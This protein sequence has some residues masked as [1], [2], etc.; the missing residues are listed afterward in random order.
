LQDAERLALSRAPDIA[1]AFFRAEAAKQVVKQARSAYFPQIT[2]NIAAVATFDDIAGSLGRSPVTGEDT[3]IGASGGLNNPT[4]LSREANGINATQ[5]LTDFGR[6][7]Y[8][9]T[10]AQYDA[11]SEAQRMQ[12]T[13]AQ[14][15][16]WVDQAYFHVLE[17]QALLHVAHE[18]VENRQ[19]IL[20]RATAFAKVELRSNLD[21]SF[22]NVGVQQARLF[23]LETETRLGSAAADLT[24][25]LGFREPRRFV[26][27][28]TTV[29]APPSQELPFLVSEALES[30]PD[31]QAL[32]LQRDS[33][34]KRASAEKVAGLPR[35]SFATS[36][37]RTAMGEERIRQTYG[38]AGVL[39]EVPIFTGGR[40]TAR[41][42]EA[43]LRAQ[44]AQQTVESAEM[45]VTRDVNITWLSMAGARKK[46]DVTET[47]LTSATD[48][49]ELA[50]S[51]YE[52][53]VASLLELS[54]ADL[55][56]TQAQIDHAT[57]KFE[58]EVQRSALDFQTG[59][60]LFALP[61]VT[62]KPLPTPHLPRAT[63]VPV[64]A[65]PVVERAR[66]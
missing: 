22:A 21:V 64:K 29:A 12:L 60:L 53:G 37:G 42:S 7:H 52:A 11:L 59:A 43:T 5:L 6:T 31:L 44:A 23:V 10:A 63:P 56:R 1:E 15:L 13:R 54:Q 32:R 26:L 17:G 3:R 14:V 25:A 28:N 2:G 9:V 40:L 49:W 24:A 50:K 38:A 34:I 47:L 46:I 8:L 51:R 45:R 58:Y 66:R 39:V 27:V 62:A 41:A 4:I 30:R 36:A 18:T 61:P 55:A 19:L 57:A 33:A 48:A 20:D 16:Y 65:A 35:I